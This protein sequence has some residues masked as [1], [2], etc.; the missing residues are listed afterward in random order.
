M[1]NYLIDKTQSVQVQISAKPQKRTQKQMAY[2]TFHTDC[3]SDHV[4]WSHYD[5]EQI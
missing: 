1:V 3:E 5:V 4:I 2:Q